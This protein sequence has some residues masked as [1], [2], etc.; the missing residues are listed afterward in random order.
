MPNLSFFWW[1]NF[2]FTKTWDSVKLCLLLYDWVSS[3]F[4]LPVLIHFVLY[5]LSQKMYD[6]F[7]VLCWIFKNMSRNL[8]FSSLLLCYALQILFKQFVGASRQCG[9]YLINISLQNIWCLSSWVFPHVTILVQKFYVA[10][11]L[12]ID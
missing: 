6:F 2:L 4:W 7:P 3:N 12:S 11:V 9:F 10:S 1:F 8:S 5:I